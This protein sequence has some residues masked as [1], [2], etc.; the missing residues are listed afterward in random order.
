M[1]S[2]YCQE[3]YNKSMTNTTQFYTGVVACYET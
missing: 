1:S 2:L 3:S